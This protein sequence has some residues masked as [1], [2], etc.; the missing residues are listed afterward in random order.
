MPGGRR[1]IAAAPVDVGGPVLDEDDDF[2]ACGG[3]LLDLLRRD[4]VPATPADLAPARR[5]AIEAFSPGYNSATIWYFVAPD[6]DRFRRIRR[7]LTERLREMRREPVVRPEAG[8]MPQQLSERYTP[9]ASR[10]ISRG[11]S[12]AGSARGARAIGHRAPLRGRSTVR[13]AECLEARHAVLLGC[14]ARRRRSRN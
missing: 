11:Q 9:S 1:L 10:A 12:A 5:H 6:V 4:G 13:R 14:A 8:A 3:V 2:G 7:A